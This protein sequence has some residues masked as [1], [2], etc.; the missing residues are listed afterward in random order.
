MNL[1]IIIPALNEE[2]NILLTLDNVLTSLK[3]FALEGEVIIVNDGSTD[4]TPSLVQEEIK[5][6]PNGIR[7]IHHTT[8]QGIGASFWD[9][10][11]AAR[12][13]AVVLIPGDNEN[14]LREILRYYQLLDSV[15]MVIPFI[16]NKEVRSFS[17]NIISFLYRFIVNTTF[18][19]NFKYTNG[20]VL[21]RSSILK[22]LNHRSCGFFYQADILIRLAKRGYLFAEVPCRLGAR[23][24]GESKAITL[25]TLRR[26]IKD[27]FGLFIDYYF[28]RKKNSKNQFLPDS[29]TAARRKLI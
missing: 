15:D 12:G 13:D 26:I 8:P 5:K 22:E 16:F 19:V 1:S 27:Y 10:V 29:V 24:E 9:G 17:R 14:D 23:K 20:T 18:G 3:E 11:D 2:K 28:K 25:K 21:Y 7:V 4:T 6:H